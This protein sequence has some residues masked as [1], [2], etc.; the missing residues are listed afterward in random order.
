MNEWNKKK[1]QGCS[2][3]CSI[4]KP[5]WC[6][7]SKS[8][9]CCR[10]PLHPL[11]FRNLDL[12]VWSLKKRKKEVFFVDWFYLATTLH[13]FSFHDFF[14]LVRAS[15]AF[16]RKTVGVCRHQLLLCTVCTEG[17]TVHAAC[18]ARPGS[19]GVA[20][21]NIFILWKHRS[22]VPKED[23][24]SEIFPFNFRG[25]VAKFSHGVLLGGGGLE[26]ALLFPSKQAQWRRQGGKMPSRRRK[27]WAD[28]G[29]VVT[30][31]LQ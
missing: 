7:L 21:L 15:T 4:Q 6:K 19:A 14:H 10:S 2:R 5:K 9:M 13:L 22:N 29:S 20:Y 16:S 26:Q 1:R 25:T 31:L 30:Q 17:C 27:P 12:L 23:R 3:C 8:G 18:R 11:W 28:P 24:K